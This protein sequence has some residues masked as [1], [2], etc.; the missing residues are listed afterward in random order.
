MAARLFAA[1]S[2]GIAAFQV[3]L[4]AGAPWGH[5]AMGGAFPGRF[6]PAMRVAA[7]AQALVLVLLGAVVMA[8]A[9]LVLPHWHAA[10]RRAMPWVVAFTVV[11]VVLNAV[12]P[13]APE[14]ALWLPVT[15]VLAVCALVVARAR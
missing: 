7:A 3:A 12:T 2:V 14:R 1:L 10:S 13:S 4:A 9:G 8:R 5:L 6:P 11:G 15:L